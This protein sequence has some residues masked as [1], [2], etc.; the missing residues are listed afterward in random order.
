MTPQRRKPRSKV[1]TW[2]LGTLSR[3]HEYL[4][5]WH[6]GTRSWEVV[7]IDRSSTV[8]TRENVQQ[9]RRIRAGDATEGAERRGLSEREP[10]ALLPEDA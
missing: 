5:F 8:I 4:L 10:A 7:M 1:R 6:E 9:S 2:S 3:N